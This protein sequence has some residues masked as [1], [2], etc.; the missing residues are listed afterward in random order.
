MGLSIC[1]LLP[2]ARRVLKIRKTMQIVLIIYLESG[3]QR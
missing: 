1:V 2:D 3:R